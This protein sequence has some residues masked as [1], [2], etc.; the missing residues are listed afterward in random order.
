ML[1]QNIGNQIAAF[2]KSKSLLS[3]IIIINVV[4]WLLSL[5]LP[6]VDYLYVFEKG[7][8]RNWYMDMFAMSS[9]VANLAHRPW[10][11]LTYMF[12]HDGFWH[13][14]FNMLMLGFGGIM[15]NRFLGSRRFGWIYF[16]SG[17][18]G[19]AFYLLIYS[20]FPVGSLHIS[21]LVGA[22]AAVLGVIV[23]VA[24]Y[25]P[26]Q[27]VTLWFIVPIRLKMKYMAL[28]FVVIDL[29]SIPVSN[30]GGHIAHLGGMLF[31]ALFVLGMR[32]D[33]K[34]SMRPKREKARFTVKKKKSKRESQGRPLTDD[35]Y[36]RRKAA[37]QKR[38]DA[39]LDKISKSGYEHLSKEE[40]EFLFNFKA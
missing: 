18:F 6:L 2:F 27:E 38:V 1:R 36:N 32:L 4:I 35:E 20:V 12:M 22:S 24:V 13:I 11:P 39:I 15:C 29:L 31:G 23:A 21:T 33:S 5:L 8:S 9:E 7:T 3:Y 16:M 26:N 37:D 28:A 34:S 17:L 30:A 19:A 10:T 25:V 14:L 40:K